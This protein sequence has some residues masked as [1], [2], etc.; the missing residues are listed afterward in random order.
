MFG[1]YPAGPNWVRTFAL[2]D[3][4]S[5][6]LQK[7]LVDLA[8]FTAAIQHQPFGQHRG[9]AL[10]QSGQ[11]LLLV[12]TTPGACEVAVTPTVEMQHLLWSYQEGYASQWS[13]AEIRSLTGHSGWPELLTNARREFSRFCDQVAAAL[14]GTLQAPPRAIASAD[15]NAPFPNEDDDAFYAQMAA[16]SA[17]MSAPEDLSCGL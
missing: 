8:G 13:A 17:S 9:A 6:D 10:A 14:D 4:S 1:L 2:G 12:A 5:R 16:M 7:S 11:T 3:C 15:I